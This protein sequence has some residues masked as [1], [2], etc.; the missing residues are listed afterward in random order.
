MHIYVYVCIDSHDSNWRLLNEK[1][2]FL[3]M[4]TIFFSHLLTD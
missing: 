4:T 1:P 2:D 3:E